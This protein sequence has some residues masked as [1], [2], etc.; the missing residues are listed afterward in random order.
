MTP[1]SSILTLIL[2]TALILSA[3][4]SDIP[5]FKIFHNASCSTPDKNL[6]LSPWGIG[7][8]FGMISCGAGRASTAE[9]SHFLG[10]TP[11][12]VLEI[13]KARKSL[14]ASKAVFNSYN[15]GFLNSRYRVN[16]KFVNQ[17]SKLY[18]GN[19]F[20]AD[21]SQ[22][23]ACVRFMN[24]IIK[25]E[26][27]GMFDNVF[28]R[29]MLADKP[30]VLFLNVLYFNGVWNDAFDKN[31]TAKETFFLQPA[32]MRKIVIDMMNDT[33]SV[34]YYND[35]TVHGIILDYK[36]RR[37]QMLVLTTID[38]NKPLSKVT[39][40]LAAKGLS[41]I[42]RNSSQSNETV[43]K[44]PKLK[45]SG[46]IDLKALFTSMG[47]T[48]IFDK[49][50]QDLTG[51]VKGESISISGARQLVKLELDE[52]KT[53]V[54]ALTYS[55][56]LS[57]AP[58]MTPPEYNYFYADHPFVLVLFDGETNA[59]LLTAAIVNPAEQ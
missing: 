58:G 3:G 18:G 12:N 34:P 13:C 28:T 6:L 42:S 29:Q 25:Q 32:S 43:I 31:A 20:Y 2:G 46:E 26:S 48:K 51:I 36:D 15:A 9:L 27:R 54:A 11:E 45:L 38:R 4:V 39:E 17:V 24:K 57:S 8:C 1:K 21:Y 44:L 7:E 55:I 52:E 50:Q 41:H 30:V 23:D 59:V 35:G 56:A 33:R 5:L 40:L 47:M 14:Q 10:L 49:K 53:E 19:L 16:Q 22:I 37:F